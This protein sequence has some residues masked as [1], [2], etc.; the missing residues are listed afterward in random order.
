MDLDR[1]RRPQGRSDAVVAPPRFHLECV[2]L[3]EVPEGDW[4]CGQACRDRCRPAAGRPAVRGEATAAPAKRE[5]GRKAKP[6][7]SAEPKSER[8]PLCWCGRPHS[9]CEQMVACERCGA[10][11]HFTCV[12]L[13]PES[14]APWLT[15]TCAVCERKGELGAVDEAP[16][17]LTSSDAD[18]VARL[19]R[20]NDCAEVFR[21]TADRLLDAVGEDRPRPPRR[22]RKAGAGLDI[23]RKDV[24]SGVA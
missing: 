16:P 4:F 1:E 7:P 14:D 21:F 18:D 5:A 2:G 12:G 13:D 6:K 15:W 24:K 22:R 8:T 17:E 10:W 9:F 11:Y 20:E 3:A 23:E 19:V